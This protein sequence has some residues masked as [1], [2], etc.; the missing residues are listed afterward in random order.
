MK[1]LARTRFEFDAFR[2][3]GIPS[4]AVEKR[5]DG[6]IGREEFADPNHL[7]EAESLIVCHAGPIVSRAAAHL[8]S[9]LAGDLLVFLLVIGDFSGAD[10]STMPT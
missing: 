6:Y 3:F 4:Q 5:I 9:C 2:G 7:A 1:R 10:V 8:Q